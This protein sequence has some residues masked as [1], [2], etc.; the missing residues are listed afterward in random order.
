MG[1][2]DQSGGWWWW[3]SPGH[4][5]W[6][7]TPAF[8]SSSIVWVSIRTVNHLFIPTFTPVPSCNKYFHGIPAFKVLWLSHFP[9]VANRAMD[10]AGEAGLSSKDSGDALTVEPGRI[11]IIEPSPPPTPPQS[12]NKQLHLLGATTISSALFLMQR[13]TRRAQTKRILSLVP[14]SD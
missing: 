12:N 6:T 8:S 5:Y 4:P 3:G 11:T 7:L 9:E 2:V 1:W 14:T 13:L 10:N